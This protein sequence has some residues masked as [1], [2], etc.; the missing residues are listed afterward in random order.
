MSEI[1]W[2]PTPEQALASNTT[3]FLEFLAATRGVSCEGWPAL[4]RFSVADPPGF[5]DALWDFAGLIGEKGPRPVTDGRPLHETRFFPEG[6]ICYAENILR[7]QGGREALVFRGE[8]GHRIAWSRDRLRAEVAALACA[9]RAE[10][11][12]PGDRIAGWLPDIPEAIAAFLA[13][14]AI[15]AVWSS[16][17]PD[18]GPAGVLDRFGQI[19][20]KLLLA[21][22]GYRYGGKVFRNLPRIAEAVAS[23]PGTKPV[24]VPFLGADAGPGEIPGAIGLEAFL[25]PHRGGALAFARR[26]FNSPLFILF[27]SGTT[28]KPKCIIHSQGGILLKHASE[29]LLH[30]D[31]RPDDRLFYFTTLG[32]MM[33]NWQ[34]SGLMTGA[35]LLLFDGNPFHPRPAA[36]FDI[37]EQERMSILGTSAKWID[38]VH[39]AGVAPHFTHD[40]ASLR[41][42]LSTGSP[43]APESFDYVYDKVKPDV[44]LASISGGTDVCGCFALGEPLGPVRRGELATRALAHDVDVV[45]DDGKPLRGGMGELVCRNAFPS[46]PLGF[47]NDEDGARYRAAYFERFPGLWHHGDFCQIVEHE[48]GSAG[49][50]IT[51]RSDAVLNPGGVRIGTAEIYR[52]VEKLPEIVESIAIGQEWKGDVRVVLFVRLA[53]EATL[54][55]ALE[56][57]I[58]RIIRD[59]ASPR[60]VPARILTVPDIPRTRSG[61]ITEIA[62]RDVVHGREVKNREALANPDAL[63]HFR[64]RAE[65]QA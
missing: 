52:Q 29:H 48:D 54:D 26:P 21:A 20:P 9:Y 36:L 64:D 39:K 13:A 1:L 53:E 47:W 27:S 55:E 16:C 30:T 11:I 22:D 37:A 23:L 18:F 49:L 17:S 40:L 25:A 31:V 45:D 8:D 34:V 43:L 51:G 38:S 6:S 59:N 19:A 65:L 2:R 50:I 44:L 15:G 3:A 12:Q 4:W 32:W 58:R 62:V 24:I 5:W 28:G 10:G 42:I 60:H 35:T 56:S 46:M 57:R 7:H 61:K 14:N 63:A 33:W 41:A